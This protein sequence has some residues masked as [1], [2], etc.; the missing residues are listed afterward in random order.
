[1]GVPLATR[2]VSDMYL[3]R[4]SNRLRLV[5]SLLKLE[6]C[7]QR[8]TTYLHMRN[9]GNGRYSDQLYCLRRSPVLC[10]SAL[11][12]YRTNLRAQNEL[13]FRPDSGVGE[14]PRGHWFASRL[15]TSNLHSEQDVDVKFHSTDL[16]SLKLRYS[17]LT[18]QHMQLCCGHSPMRSRTGR[19]R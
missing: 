1:M 5:S 8:C 14:V 18:L 13:E 9:A 2:H 19:S 7:V 4:Y 10:A 12:H 11:A 17:A 15:E 16:A 3:R 6:G